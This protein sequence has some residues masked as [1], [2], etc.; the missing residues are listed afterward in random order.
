MSKLI[1]GIIGA[2]SMGTALAMLLGNDSLDVVVW[3]RRAEVVRSI[4]EFGENREYFPGVRLP[5]NV[6]ATDDLGECLDSDILFIAVPS[7][8]VREVC[9]RIREAGGGDFIVVNTAKGV[10]YPPLKRL[11]MVIR[12]V[13]GDVRPVVMSGP[14]F[15]SEIVRGL[16][17]GTTI[18]GEDRDALIAVK[19]VL[20]GDSFIVQV[21]DDVVG[22][23]LGGVL[24]NVYAIAMGICDAL[25]VNENAYYFVLTEAFREM[26][27]IIVRLGGRPETLFLSSGFGDLCLTS[28]S[29]K[30]R[31]RA[32][33]FIA[34]KEMLGNTDR[35]TVVL[36]G[37]KSVRAF[38]D[39]VGEWGLRC[40]VLEFV[41]N[42]LILRRKPYNEFLR[43]WRNIKELY[44]D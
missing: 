7:H 28:S 3:A 6:R 16:P 42:V 40:P 43:L 23:E 17:S 27:D 37:M 14:N 32:L 24:K 41:Y 20:H 4:N 11:S 18:A 35:S 21:S 31:N 36:E 30:S 8:A 25:G 1:I 13:L 12:E 29:N 34:G 9:M 22:V 26:R 15:A 38:H 5:P 10:E 33:G 19:R 44:D 39:L 2:G